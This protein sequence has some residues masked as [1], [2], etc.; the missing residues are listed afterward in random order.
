MAMDLQDVV[1][2]AHDWNIA[3]SVDSEAMS[4]YIEGA[5]V[6]G[7]IPGALSRVTI[8]LYAANVDELLTKLGGFANE[9][10]GVG[11]LEVVAD[12]YE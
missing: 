9:C 4:H 6:S 10:R 2:V 1:S 11:K 12:G 3:V 8:V 7:F 5:R